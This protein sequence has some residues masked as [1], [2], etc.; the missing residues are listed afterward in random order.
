MAASLALIKSTLEEADTLAQKAGWDQEAAEEAAAAA[1]Y[2]A[3]AAVKSAAA[4]VTADKWG[5][6]PRHHIFPG[7]PA[8]FI[9]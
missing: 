2:A 9:Q 7:I 3:A 5:R 6:G 8:V 1:K 4:L